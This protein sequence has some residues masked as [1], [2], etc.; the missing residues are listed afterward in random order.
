VT[1]LDDQVLVVQL[2]CLTADRAPAEQRALL[3]IAKR[4]ELELNSVTTRNLRARGA[5]ASPSWLVDDVEGSYEP[6]DGR[7]VALSA[8]DRARIDRQRRLF[9][10]EHRLAWRGGVYGS[11]TNVEREAAGA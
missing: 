1:L 4:A 2:A 6:T 11:V 5:D 3:N 8:K 7:P 10:V 9:A